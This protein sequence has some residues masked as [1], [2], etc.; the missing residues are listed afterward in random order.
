MALT[1]T[2]K[3]A[4]LLA[5]IIALVDDKFPEDEAQ[6]IKSFV[7]H[8]YHYVAPEELLEQGSVSDLYG[9]A[10]AYWRF[11][12]QYTADQTKIR[13]YNPQF[14]QEGWQSAH[15]IVSLIIKDMP[16]L[17]DSIRMALNRQGLTVHL[18]VIT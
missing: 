5:K 9:A 3:A 18:I 6:Q 17:V 11:A 13:V 8:F 7:E 16:F 1:P 4:E 10:V 14:E 15:T 12:R 2:E